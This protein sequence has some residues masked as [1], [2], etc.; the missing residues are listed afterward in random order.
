[1][2]VEVIIPWAGDCPFRSASL[3]WVVRWWAEHHPDH[4]VTV[5]ETT[6]DPWVK[7]AAV[8]PAAQASSADLLV[9]HD[10]DV[11][12]EGTAEAVQRVEAG[13][14]WAIPH[15]RVHRLTAD[16]TAAVLTG[17]PPERLPLSEPA[18]VGMA[19][20]GIV[21][22]PRSTY[23]EVPLDPRFAGWGG[24]DEAWG[25][26]LACIHGGPW[27]DRSPLW[28]LWHPPQPRTTRKAG[29]DASEALRRRYWD[30]RRSPDHMRALIEEVPCRTSASS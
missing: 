17:S 6:V 9:I 28:H 4:L 22:L 21:V 23:L 14:A 10:A 15:R 27:R 16:A 11:W 25:G 2:A 3:R 1:V 7:A 19:G 29:S 24:E 13:H 26:A 12:C 8:T 18:Y 30:A 20:G 5:A